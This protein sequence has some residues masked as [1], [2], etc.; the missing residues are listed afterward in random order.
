VPAVEMNGDELRRYV[1]ICDV[2]GFSE[3]VKVSDLKTLVNEYEQL[4]AE[5]RSCTSFPITK[6]AVGSLNDP[7]PVEMGNYNIDYCIFSD[8]I[9]LWSEAIV[10]SCAEGL[11]PYPWAPGW[12]FFFALSRLVGIGLIK[13]LPLRIG[14][15]FG[16]SVMDAYRRIY[17]GKAVVD[18]Y[19]T[20][21]RQEWI[22]VAC[23]PSC[24]DA[25]YN[26][27]LCSRTVH[28]G[29]IPLV[30]YLGEAEGS[31]PNN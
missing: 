27:Q 13:G 23:H 6:I 17:V 15:A 16:E 14:V 24:L 25:P 31:A 3:R 5:V 26:D 7:G 18:A 2:L 10:S 28:L 1:A 29:S 22:G 21:H 4:L 9:I 19:E 12:L 8:S 20:E 11:S 30:R